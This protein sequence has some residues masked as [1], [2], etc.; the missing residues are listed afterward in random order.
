MAHDLRWGAA[1]AKQTSHVAHSAVDVMEEAAVTG[2]Q[3]VQTFFL[4]VRRLN[5]AVARAF[6]LAGEAHIAG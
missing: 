6:A 4:A 1:A 3:V 5:E 2:A